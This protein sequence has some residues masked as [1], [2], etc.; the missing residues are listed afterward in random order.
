MSIDIPSALGQMD[1]VRIEA[2]KAFAEQVEK[3]M[4]DDIKWRLHGLVDTFS[5]EYAPIDTI[6][7][8]FELAKSISSSANDL[9]K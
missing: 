3:Y 2:Q 1:N 4:G 7:D 9:V 8:A 5:L 6:G